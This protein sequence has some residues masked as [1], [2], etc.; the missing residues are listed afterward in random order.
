VN[1][2]CHH[3]QRGGAATGAAQTSGLAAAVMAALTLCWGGTQPAAAQ[4]MAAQPTAAAFAP[5]IPNQAPAPGPAPEGMVWIPG[6]E[7]SM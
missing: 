3:T 7:F 6:G 1:A 4:P 5:T 2:L